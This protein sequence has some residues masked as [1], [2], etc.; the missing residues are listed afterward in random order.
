MIP[1]SE[2]PNTG[3]CCAGSPSTSSSLLQVTNLETSLSPGM[4]RDVFIVNTSHKKGV[5]RELTPVDYS[6]YI[7]RVIPIFLF[8]FT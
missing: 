5:Q 3:D 4:Q 7:N 1:K 8:Y 2:I 6:L